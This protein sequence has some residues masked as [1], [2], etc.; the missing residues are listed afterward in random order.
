MSA[1]VT[2]TRLT[3]PPRCSIAPPEGSTALIGGCT[4]LADTYFRTITISAW[5]LPGMFFLLAL[6]HDGVRLGRK[7]YVVDLASGNKRTDYVAISN[8]IIGLLLLIVGGAVAWLQHYDIV[9]TILLLSMCALSSVYF[10][11]RLPE[12]QHS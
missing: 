6:I 4:F 3:A 1:T 9:L 10:T 12:T 11:L 5:F 2:L 8:S 7:T